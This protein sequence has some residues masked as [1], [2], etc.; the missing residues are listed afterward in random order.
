MAKKATKKVYCP[1]H[2]W[3]LAPNLPPCR[4]CGRTADQLTGCKACDAPERFV[5]HTCG[6]KGL[7]DLLSW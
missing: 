1:S 4:K 7:Q 3:E 5:R 6:L 2:G